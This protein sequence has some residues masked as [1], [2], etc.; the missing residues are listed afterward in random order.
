MSDFE[1]AVAAPY[2]KN[3]RKTEFT[4]M[5]FEFFYRM[6]RKWMS[7]DQVKKFISAAERKGYLISSGGGYLLAKELSEISV[8]VGFK[9][10]DEIFDETE[11][12]EVEDLLADISKVSGKTSQELAKEMQELISHFD[13]L[14]LP[15]AAILLLAKKYQ[16][17]P[18]AYE[19]ELC[20]RIS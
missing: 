1:I 18:K 2:K 3:I 9:P 6:D 14:I 19:N 13:D 12:D 4:L 7:G 5:D 17:D 16:V 8:P 15:E 10:S 20:K 11:G